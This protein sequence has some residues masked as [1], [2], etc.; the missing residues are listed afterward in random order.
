MSTFFDDFTE[1]TVSDGAVS[2]FSQPWISDSNWSIAGDVLTHQTASNAAARLLVAEG[3]TGTDMDACV[4]STAYRTDAPN[5]PQ[6]NYHTLILRASGTMATRTGI[7]IHVR[8]TGN[9]SSI[10]PM[11]IQ[12]H[13]A[14]GG[15]LNLLREIVIPGWI[16]GHSNRP[17]RVRARVSDR[18]VQAKAWFDGQ[19]EP[20]WMIQATTKVVSP[21]GAGFAGWGDSQ[22]EFHWFGASTEGAPQQGPA[23][24]PDRHAADYRGPAALAVSMSYPLYG[25]GTD[26]HPDCYTMPNDDREVA[27][28][29]YKSGRQRALTI[30]AQIT[31]QYPVP[32]IIPQGFAHCSKFSG[33]VIR[34]TIDPTFPGDYT[35]WQTDY[36]TNPF[37][38]WTKV[39]T[40]ETYDLAHARPGDVWVTRDPGHV[41]VWIGAHA[42]HS[43]VV[44]E[45]AYN[46]VNAEYGLSRVGSLRRFYLNAQGLDHIDRPYDCWRFTGKPG[47]QW[48]MQTPTGV[49]RVAAYLQ[50]PD[51]LTPVDPPD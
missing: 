50:T 8:S 14:T 26:P 33:T 45:A 2:G 44:S 31:D 41:F 16:T 32:G 37:N 19:P 49:T 46:G 28:P 15:P 24:G 7:V 38:G 18:T 5:F 23:V 34:N 21:G 17:I 1:T 12:I 39:M 11:T 22:Q 40:A 4:M 3:F 42:G 20:A 13:E 10:E 48:L 47:R 30:D 36:L 27:L 35:G 25:D 9:V 29:T 43:D 51:G 6:G